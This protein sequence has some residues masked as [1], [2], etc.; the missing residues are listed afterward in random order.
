MAVRTARALVGVLFARGRGIPAGSS[1]R[2]VTVNDI[3]PTILAWL[4]LPVAR[5]MDGRPMAS[6]DVEHVEPIATYDTKPI[7]R[8]ESESSAAEAEILEELRALGYLE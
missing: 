2:G 8:L 5:D 7:P 3:T 4:G 1:T 6:L